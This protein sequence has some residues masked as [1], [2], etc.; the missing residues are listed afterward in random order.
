VAAAI[1][2]RHARA[3]RVTS[4]LAGPVLAGLALLAG[5]A[6]TPNEPAAPASQGP[7][8]S[9][10]SFSMD[11][12]LGGGYKFSQIG[13]DVS[14]NGFHKTGTVDVAASTTVST[15][16]GGIPL[17]T[18]YKLQLTAQDTAHKLTPCVGSATFSITG[19]GTIAVPVHLTCHEAPPA[20][21]TAVPVPRWATAVLGG[22]LFGLGIAGARRRPRA[23]R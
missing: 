3:A 10:G 11:L 23:A 15:V 16:V 21:T 2:R 19:G 5:C 17:G 1:D 22:L 6:S 18:G 9:V 20:S 13:Y 7:D 8:P 12:T 14:G 4:R